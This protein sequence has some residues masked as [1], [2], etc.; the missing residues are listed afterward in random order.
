VEHTADGSRRQSGYDF[1][2]VNSV[3]VDGLRAFSAN[4][5]AREI[6]ARMCCSVCLETARPG[7]LQTSRDLLLENNE[8][9]G[10]VVTTGFTSPTAATAERRGNRC[11]DNTGTGIQNAD[12]HV[13]PGGSIITGA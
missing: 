10:S 3:V 4:R 7:D 11:H 8:C 2:H 13:Q 12:R 9:F 1:H 6:K 5:A